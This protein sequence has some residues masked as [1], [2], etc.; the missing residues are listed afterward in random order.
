[1]KSEVIFDIHFKIKVREYLAD[2]VFVLW[3]SAHDYP[4]ESIQETFLCSLPSTDP[5]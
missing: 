2:Q 5:Y 4:L 1:M 3:L